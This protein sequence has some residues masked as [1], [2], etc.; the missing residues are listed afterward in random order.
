M[1]QNKVVEVYTEGINVLLLK[2]VNFK[3]QWRVQQ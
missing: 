1:V 3:G 2:L